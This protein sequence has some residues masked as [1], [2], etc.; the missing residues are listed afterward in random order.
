MQNRKYW[1]EDRGPQLH[2]REILCLKFIVTPRQYIM[3]FIMAPCIVSTPLA[4][5]Y[6]TLLPHTDPGEGSDLA[7]Q[8][9]VFSG[10]LFML[11]Q[12][13]E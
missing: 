4:R 1:T 11:I 6:A 3:L 8:Q 9:T 13:G 2:T 10:L 5:R 7:Y 12:P